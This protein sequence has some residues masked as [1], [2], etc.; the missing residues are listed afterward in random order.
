MNAIQT[1]RSVLSHLFSAPVIVASLGYFVDVYDLLIF[2][3]VRIPSLK[4]MGLSAAE[5]STVG[6]S[7]LNWQMSGLFLGGVLWGVLGDKKGRLSVLFSSIITYSVAHIACAYVQD[8]ATYKALRF[9]A[10]VGLA[11]ELGAGV[12]LVSEILPKEIRSLGSSLIGGIGMLG[13]VFAMPTSWGAEWAFCFCC[14]A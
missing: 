2:G 12:T 3:I 13:A 14:C 1:N 4:S 9:I 10:G 8:P 5:I 6:A 7:I 11:G